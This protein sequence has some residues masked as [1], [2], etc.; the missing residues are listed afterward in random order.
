MLYKRNVDD[1]FVM[2]Q[3]RDNGKRFVDY[4]NTKHTNIRFT[5]EMEDVKKATL[6]AIYFQR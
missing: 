3:F 6:H 4:V 1:I 5:F 2:F